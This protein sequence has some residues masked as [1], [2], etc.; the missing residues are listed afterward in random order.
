MATSG[1]RKRPEVEPWLV[2]VVRKVVL[3][4]ALMTENILALLVAERDKLNRAIEALQGPIKRRGRP[5]KNSSA[6]A[7]VPDATMPARSAKKRKGGMS[8]AGR[9]AQSQRTKA[10]WAA[11][12]KKQ[13]KK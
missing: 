12:R 13:V 8:A 9:K 7:P 1:A 10:Y 3:R 6:G 11:K 5:P 4:S 2:L